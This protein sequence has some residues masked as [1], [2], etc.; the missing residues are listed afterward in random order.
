MQK[1]EV[2]S[3]KITGREYRYSNLWCQKISDKLIMTW[4]AFRSLRASVKLFCLWQLSVIVRW[5]QTFISSIFSAVLWLLLVAGWKSVL[6][7]SSWSI[8]SVLNSPKYAVLGR[9]RMRES[10]S[11]FF[12]LWTTSVCAAYKVSKKIVKRCGNPISCK[13][14]KCIYTFLTGSH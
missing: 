10:W 9:N 2:N 4:V 6:S 5:S 12:I 14:V 7:F 13:E 11:L 8:R 1:K 3:Y